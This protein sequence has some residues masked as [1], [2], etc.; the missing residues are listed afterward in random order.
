MVPNNAMR[1]PIRAAAFMFACLM[2]TAVRASTIP[3][4]TVELTG[5]AACKSLP[6]SAIQ[7]GDVVTAT[8]HN[9]L[10]GGAVIND[11]TVEVRR[12]GSTGNP[13]VVSGGTVTNGQASNTQQAS[14]TPAGT[15][16]VVDFDENAFPGTIGGNAS[17][18]VDLVMGN[19]GTAQD[20]EICFVPTIATADGEA[21]TLDLFEF[22]QQTDLVRK[23]IVS[24]W[25]AVL[26]APVRNSDDRLDIVQLDGVIT[27]PPGAAAALSSVKIVDPANNFQEVS[28]VTVT[29]SG[30]SFSISGF[31]L[32]PPASY[33]VLATFTQPFQGDLVKM[34]L[35][36]TF[37]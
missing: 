22:N 12:K 15:G 35:E 34:R 1:F 28:G 7:A 27:R 13:P 14:Q 33:H 18:T 24:M 25:R 36:P 30:D 26:S 4:G 32:A 17:A 5:G 19:P 11:L 21:N 8:I 3:L 6:V 31:R 9:M 29:I 23:T 20:M 2:A 10:A 16:S 37:D